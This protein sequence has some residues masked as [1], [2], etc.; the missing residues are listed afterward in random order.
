MLE[1]CDVYIYS[2]LGG[3]LFLGEPWPPNSYQGKILS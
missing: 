3:R 2:P 1:R